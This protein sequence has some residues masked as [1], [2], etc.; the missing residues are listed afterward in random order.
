MEQTGG[1]VNIHLASIG[2]IL[3]DLISMENIAQNNFLLMQLNFG[4]SS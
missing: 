4:F 1:V 2:P 3:K